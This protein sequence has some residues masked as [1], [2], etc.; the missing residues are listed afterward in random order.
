MVAM[1]GPLRETKDLRRAL[2]RDPDQF[3]P[4][5]AEYELVELLLPGAAERLLACRDDEPEHGT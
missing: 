3:G 5:A 2:T 4:G 1:T